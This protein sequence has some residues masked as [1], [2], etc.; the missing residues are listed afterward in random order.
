MGTN[1]TTEILDNDRVGDLKIFYNGNVYVSYKPLTKAE[2]LVIGHGKVISYGSNEE[3]LKKYGNAAELIDVH[4]KTVLPGF[5]DS[6]VHLD[7]IGGSLNFLNLR[8]VSSIDDLKSRLAEYR[9]SNSRKRVFIGMGWDQE[10]F[11]EKRWPCASDLDSVE[12]DNPVFLERY[13]EHAAVA[14][15]KMLEMAGE[16]SFSESIF[17]RDKKGVPLG[18]VK[19][20]AYDYFKEKALEISNSL[21][22]NLLKA[23]DFMVQNGVTSTGFVSCSE[24]VADAIGKDRRLI[25]PRIRIYLNH[26]HIDHF[27]EIRNRTGVDDHIKIVGIKLFVDGALGART[28]FLREPY[29][30]DRENRGYQ[31]M[32][33]NR[34]NEIATKSYG[35][36][37][38]LAMHAIGDAGIDFILNTFSKLD[39]NKLTRPRIEHCVVLRHDQVGKIRDLEL[40]VCVGPASVIDDWWVVDRLGRERSELAYP[41]TTLLEGGIIVGISTDSPVE[42]VDPWFTVDASVNRGLKEGIELLKFSEKERIDLATTLYLYTEGSA[43]LIGEERNLGNLEPGKFADFIV[44][45]EDPFFTDELRGIKT[46]ETYVGGQRVFA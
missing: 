8:D 41:L 3:S 13:C 7:D 20:K 39:R 37:L 22:E 40:G 26:E 43:W 27:E 31:A 42:P 29:S 32:D 38:Q 19:E 9:V 25:K 46:L 18:I 2:S 17:P 23:C 44:V 33:E 14:N 6:H 36:D 11:K 28:A 45:D 35:K 5:V 10:K 34:L 12:K 30:D 15:S 24:E 21:E 1:D 16:V 4:G